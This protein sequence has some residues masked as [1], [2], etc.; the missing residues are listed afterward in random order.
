MNISMNLEICAYLLMHGVFLF[1][2]DIRY[3]TFEGYDYD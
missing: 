1:L 2:K 3:E